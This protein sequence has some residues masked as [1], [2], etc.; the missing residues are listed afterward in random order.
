MTPKTSWLLFIFLLAFTACS[1]NTPEPSSQARPG[2]MLE[3]S[4]TQPAPTQ[5]P[6]PSSTP[7]PAP[8]ATIPLPTGRPQSGLGIVIP[9]NTQGWLSADVWLEAGD[10]IT[11]TAG[12]TINIW[13]NCEETKA[14]AGFADLDCTL[15]T[16]I[17]PG[18][19]SAFEPAKEDYPY[20]GGPVAALVG[21][22]AEGAPFL[23]GDQRVYSVENSGMLAFA[24][25]DVSSLSDNGGEFVVQ[26]T[27][28]YAISPTVINGD[29]QQ[30][31]I[32]LAAGQAFTITAS[33]SVNMWP[34]CEETKGEQGFPNFD[35]SV[36]AA[37]GPGGTDVFAP[38]QEDYPLPGANTLALIGRVGN[39][40]A[41]VIGDGG[42]FVAPAGGPLLVATND[43]AYWKQD[44]QGIFIVTVSLIESGE[45][46]NLE[47][48]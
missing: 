12:G 6:E 43:T 39:S 22:V 17:G 8:T 45:V 23:A 11:I 19:T 37:V 28:P 20:P 3:P 47:I 46:I 30:T 14:S 7:L 42:A 21:R 29:W 25:N 48:R 33:G 41:F 34:N 16:A 31:G 2:P 32:V 18:G 9:G 4:A 36:T 1:Q 5:A 10:T 24:I 44:D 26:L 15:V 40:A 27:V 13:P 35:C 38:G